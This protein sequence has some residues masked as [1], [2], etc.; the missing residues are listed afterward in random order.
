[1][2]KVNWLLGLGDGC[3]AFS[4]GLGLAGVCSCG[5]CNWGNITL[6]RGVLGVNA[7]LELLLFLVV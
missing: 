5:I 6:G 2:G 3:K 7:L 4:E 1:M